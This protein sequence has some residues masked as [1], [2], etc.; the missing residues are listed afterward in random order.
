MSQIEVKINDAVKML[1]LR[2]DRWECLALPCNPLVTACVFSSTLSSHMQPTE[3]MCSD[4]GH[5]ILMLSH[6][7]CHSH[8]N[9]FLLQI[10]Y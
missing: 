5:L 7:L 3:E 9:F 1:I 8:Y 2:L 6:F 10:K 4:W